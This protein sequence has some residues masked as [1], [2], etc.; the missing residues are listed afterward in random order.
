MPDQLRRV[1][2]AVWGACFIST[3]KSKVAAM[4]QKASNLLRVL[5]KIFLQNLLARIVFYA[6]HYLEIYIITMIGNRAETPYK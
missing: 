4:K 3:N 5:R 1:S 2:N 6:S